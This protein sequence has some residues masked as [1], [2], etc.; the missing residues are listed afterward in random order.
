MLTKQPKPKLRKTEGTDVTS[1]EISTDDITVA[2]SR[3]KSYHSRFAGHWVSGLCSV[4]P[5]KWE[6]EQS[7]I[8][9][10]LYGAS[11]WA[12]LVKSAREADEADQ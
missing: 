11:I 1:I 3:V 7:E 12:E 10:G 4:Y 9:D 8:V 5:H 2:L 6:I